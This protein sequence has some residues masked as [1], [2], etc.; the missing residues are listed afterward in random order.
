MWKR[1]GTAQD[2]QTNTPSSAESV[3]E[4]RLGSPPEHMKED[5]FDALLRPKAECFSGSQF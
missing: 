5:D 2:V 3:G 1:F 4:R